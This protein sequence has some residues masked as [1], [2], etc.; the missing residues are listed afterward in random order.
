M[1]MIFVNDWK[2]RGTFFKLFN[3]DLS[4][5]HGGVWFEFTILGLGIFIHSSNV[6]DD[7]LKI[8]AAYRAQRRGLHTQH[9][10]PN[11]DGGS[12]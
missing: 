3:I 8:K 9:R 1:K 12:R 6:N 11:L 10:S 5:L 2:K 4:E 7:K